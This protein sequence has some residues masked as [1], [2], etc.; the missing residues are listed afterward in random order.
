MGAIFKVTALIVYFVG[1][2]WGLFMCLGIVVSKLGFI[3]GAIAFF[4]FPITLYFAPW[5]AALARD[6][7][8]PVSLVYGTSIGA[9][10]L[11]SIGSAIDKE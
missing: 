8:F 2:L 6:D 11:Y 9:A 4:F 1:G 7:W 3:G 10:I 5:Y